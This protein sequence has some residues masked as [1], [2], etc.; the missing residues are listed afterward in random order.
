MLDN[1]FKIISLKFNQLVLWRKIMSSSSERKR[2]HFINLEAEIDD[3][4]KD[5]DYLNSCNALSPM[6]V[7]QL[8]KKMRI[9][10]I[11]W[12][13]ELEGKLPATKK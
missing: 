1:Y 8:I 2:R 10:E 6:D 4:I 7:L 5:L 13:T 11:I 12:R 9:A 3:H